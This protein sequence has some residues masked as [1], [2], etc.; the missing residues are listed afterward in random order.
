M[1]FPTHCG[2]SDSLNVLRFC[3]KPGG[4]KGQTSGLFKGGDF[5][6]SAR[7]SILELQKM[8][9]MRNKEFFTERRGEN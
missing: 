4:M 3:Y 9:M 8:I 7:P 2:W 6:D 1:C 5:M